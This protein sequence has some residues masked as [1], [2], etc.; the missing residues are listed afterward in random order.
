MYSSEKT[1]LQPLDSLYL[2]CHSHR[3]LYFFFQLDLED[4][5]EGCHILLLAFS[6]LNCNSEV[7]ISVLKPNVLIF[8]NKAA[9]G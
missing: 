3:H 5:C 6:E 8:P 7:L 9:L 2:G 1:F 4:L